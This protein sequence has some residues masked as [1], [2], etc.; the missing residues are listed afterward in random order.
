MDWPTLPLTDDARAAALKLLRQQG[1]VQDT[2]NGQPRILPY[3]CLV[4]FA[5]GTLKG[6]SKAWRGFPTLC[7]HLGKQRFVPD[8]RLGRLPRP[9]DA[10]IHGRITRIHIMRLPAAPSSP[11]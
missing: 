4:P 11:G 8:E 7:R 6:A 5:S 10:R 2:D 1:L 3:A 9:D